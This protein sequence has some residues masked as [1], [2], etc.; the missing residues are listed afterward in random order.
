MA[1]YSRTRGWVSRPTFRPL[2]TGPDPYD[3]GSAHYAERHRETST[4]LPGGLVRIDI[5]A[6]VPRL[7]SE[8]QPVSSRVARVV[9]DSAP[10]GPEGASDAPPPEAP[11]EP[12]KVP[13]EPREKR[14]ITREP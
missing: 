4:A 5:G 7:P 10:S 13:R 2:D 8:P 12:R 6:P 14:A 11:K 1:L 3:V 9:P